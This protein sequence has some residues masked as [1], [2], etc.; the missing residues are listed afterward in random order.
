MELCGIP[1]KARVK[2]FHR[3]PISDNQKSQELSNI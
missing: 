3:M 2:Y 1:D